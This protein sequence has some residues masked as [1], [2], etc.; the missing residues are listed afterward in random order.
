MKPGKKKL[1][2]LHIIRRAVQIAAFLLFPGLFF[3][4]FAAL[5][6]IVSALAGGSFDPAAL[7]RQLI[8]ACGT[9]IVT[10]VMG[11]FFCGFLCAFGSM[12]DFLWFVARR[13]K[14]SRWRIGR[15]PDRILKAVKYALLIAI[16]A[17]V[18]IGGVS[19]NSLW[20]PWNIFGRYAS[21]SGWPSPSYLIS[22]GGALLLAI[23][24]GSLFIER[25]FC[26]YLC[27]LGAV[28]AA[29][30]GFRLFRIRKPGKQCGACRACTKDCAMGIPLYEMDAVSSGECIDC[31][32][33]VEVC[34]R[35]NV[36]TN[37]APAV[38]ALVTAGAL[39]GLYYAGN[40]AAV[41][42]PPP[43]Q[44][45]VSAPNQPP[46]ATGGVDQA[47]G[48]ASNLA[49]GVYTGSGFGYRGTTTVS[50]TV[51][52]GVITDVTVVSYL[53]DDMFFRWAR[54]GVIPA[55]LSSQSV[56]VPVVSGATYSSNGILEAVSNALRS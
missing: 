14:L 40:L 10:A 54:D 9:L 42:G 41:S 35:D 6:D 12:G 56:D 28:F 16:A 29:V 34:P 52:G 19:V 31:F 25:F 53:D 18:W 36:S 30:S 38:A 27:P 15:K 7:S 33:C 2:A 45:N 26:R 23:I 5:G 13:L 48:A 20:N 21:V 51:S 49:D 1:I 50:V 39:T 47:G 22:V 32:Q 46:P 8:L 24:I 44:G 3:F 4:V 37:P 17:F 11:R 55:I 43:A